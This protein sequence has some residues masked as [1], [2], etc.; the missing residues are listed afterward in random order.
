VGLLG[1]HLIGVPIALAILLL[2]AHPYTYTQELI[3]QHRPEMLR[4]DLWEYVRE[5]GALP[6]G[7]TWEEFARNLPGTYHAYDPDTWS[8]G[9]RAEYRRFDRGEMR[10]HPIDFNAGCS[11]ITQADL[12][13]RTVW[14]VRWPEGSGWHGIVFTGGWPRQSADPTALGLAKDGLHAP[15]G[16]R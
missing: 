6:S 8:L 5:H 10:R 2:P 9:Y 3:N 15:D 7:T 4:M 16:S 11:G 13:D 1:V 12:G 14:I